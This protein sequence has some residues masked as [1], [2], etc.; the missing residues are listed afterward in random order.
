VYGCRGAMTLRLICYKLICYNQGVATDS[1]SV[2][3]VMV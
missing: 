1:K 3:G 2:R